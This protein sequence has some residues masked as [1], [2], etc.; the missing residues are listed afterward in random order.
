MLND[1]EML[2]VRDKCGFQYG[3]A[4]SSVRRSRGLVMFWKDV[5]DLSFLF[6]D[7]KYVICVIKEVGKDLWRFAEIYGWSEMS[8]KY[9]I[10]NLLR[11][12]MWSSD[13][14]ILFGG[15]FNEILESA[16]K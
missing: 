8:Q 4:V 7:R 13:L 1:K 16:E 10:W 11:D 2:K 6:Y 12:L 9:K 15:D 3:M 5:I 14:F